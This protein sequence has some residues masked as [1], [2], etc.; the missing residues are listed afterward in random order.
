MYRN[1]IFYDHSC[2]RKHTQNK[3]FNRFVFVKNNGRFTQKAMAAKLP[4]LLVFSRLFRGRN[5]CLCFCVDISPCIDIVLMFLYSGLSG[6]LGS[7]GKQNTAYDDA[8]GHE[9]CC[10]F[11]Y[12]S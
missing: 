7:E 10:T 4:P 8:R 2:D 9:N 12:Y 6:I 1:T 11:H 3:L 5:S